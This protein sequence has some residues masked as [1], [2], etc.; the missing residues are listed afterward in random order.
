MVVVAPF[1]S[2]VFAVVGS[3]VVAGGAAVATVAEVDNSELAGF[4]A[5]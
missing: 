4:V 2:A 5:R 3:A 1:G